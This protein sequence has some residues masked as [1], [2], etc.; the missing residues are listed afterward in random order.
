MVAAVLLYICVVCL[1]VYHYKY[2]VDWS[3]SRSLRMHDATTVV[4]PG[5]LSTSPTNSMIMCSICMVWSV[6]GFSVGRGCIL[7]NFC[8]Q[9]T[10]AACVSLK[11]AVWPDSKH[12]NDCFLPWLCS[13]ESLVVL[14]FTAST[15]N[16]SISAAWHV[17]NCMPEVGF[18]F[19]L[20]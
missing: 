16:V 2:Q 5:L 14:C 6:P 18:H 15:R 19:C 1:E 7:D 20:P 11:L 12:A 8:K 10:I 9:F 17:G 4:G 13:S 3:L